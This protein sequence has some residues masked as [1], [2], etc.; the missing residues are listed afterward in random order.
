MNP[1]DR[2]G[3]EEAL[4]ARMTKFADEEVLLTNSDDEDDDESFRGFRFPDPI[5][6]HQISTLHL[7]EH[8]VHGHSLS[9]E[10]LFEIQQS[11]LQAEL[12][13][14][15]MLLQLISEETGCEAGVLLQAG[16]ELSMADP[17]GGE[18]VL[19]LKQT[20]PD[21]RPLL[22]RK[23]D[24]PGNPGFGEG[25]VQLDLSGL[26]EP[27]QALREWRTWV[28]RPFQGA[29][30][31]EQDWLVY[32][33]R[34]VISY[35]AGVDEPLKPFGYF[36][37]APPWKTPAGT[38]QWG[39]ERS[40]VWTT[41]LELPVKPL[42]DE[43]AA[44]T[45]DKPIPRYQMIV[46]P[47]QFVHQTRGGTKW[48]PCEFDI[49]GDGTPSLVGGMRSHK[50]PHL[51][52]HVA[53]PVLSEALPLL[54]KLRR[55][56]LLL[57]DRRLQVVFKAQRIIVPGNSGDNSDAEYVGLW[58][59]DGLRENVAAVVLYYYHV[60]PSLRGGDME[61]CGREPMDVLGAGDCSNNIDDLG[62]ESLRLAFRGK[63]KSESDK[64]AAVHNCRVPI[65]EGT[66]LVFSNYQ[67][68]HRVLRMK[69]TGETEASRDF[70]AL[71]V[72][73]PSAP[74]LLPARS[75]LAA[76]HLLTR[77]LAPANIPISEIQIVLEFLGVS[78]TD[79][80]R[81]LQRNRLLSEQLKP[82][83]EFACA[84]SAKVH[85]TG[86]GCYT[87]IGWLHKLL[88]DRDP[89][90]FDEVNPKGL[91]RL[92]ALNLAPEGSDRGL[93]EAL[94]LPTA[95]LKQR[96][97]E[98]GKGSDSEL[99]S[100]HAF[101]DS[102]EAENDMRLAESEDLKVSE[103]ALTG[104]PDDVSKTWKLKPK[105]EGEPEKL[106]PEVCVFS[107]CNVTNG[108]GRG[109]VTAT[110]MRTRI[111]RIAQLIAGEEGP[112]K[113]CFC[114]PDTSANQTPLQRN[115]EQLGAKIG[116]LAIVVCVA[117][118]IIGVV[119][120]RKDLDSPESPA[121]LYMV[122]I[123]VTLAVAAIPEGIPLCVTISL[124]IGCSDMVK[125]HVLVRK[126]A[127]V[128]T[129]GSASVICS[130][131]TGTLTEGKMTM[132]SMWSGDVT[133]DVGGK[134]FDPTVGKITAPGGEDAAL[135]LGVKTTLLSGL[136]CCNTTLDKVKDAD[137]GEE[138]WEP[139]GNS[140]EA[141]IVVAAR[142]IGFSEDVATD[143]PREL[144][145][146]FSSSRK[147][148]LTVCS[149]S[150]RHAICDG[151]MPL[152][153]GTK[154]FLVCKGA[155]NFIIDLCEE[156]LRD[157]G[158]VA[159]MTDEAR[160]DILKVVDEYSSKALRVLAVAVRT[161]TELPFDK[162]DD[163]ISTD[164][165][166]AKLRQNL[167]L[168]GLVASIDPDRDGVKDSVLAARG[169]GIRVVMIT[170]DYLKTAI[171]IAKNVSILQPQDD[172]ATA[173]VDCNTLRPGGH[174]LE[175][176]E[177]DRLT[178]T[179]RVFARAK[180]EDK[181]E[182]VKSIQRMGQ[183]A[184]MTGDGVND[185]PALNQ[186]NIGVAMGI[187]GTEVAKGASDMVLTDDNFCSIVSAVEKGR[188]I[189]SGIQKFVAFIMSVHIAE[190][191]QIFACIVAGIPVMRTP[192]QIL[193]LI[194]VTD[195]PP[196]IALGMEPGE[197]GILN[198]RPRPKTEP[199]VLGWM[200]FAMVLNGAVLSIVIIAVYIISLI[201]Y[202]D[203]QILQADIMALGDDAA[204]KLSQART[205]TFISLVWSENIRSYI[206]RSFDK[207][208][209][210]NLCG[211]SMM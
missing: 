45:L 112:K 166:F 196:S 110:G 121:A 11:R 162:N 69:N 10:K 38:K 125:Q 5:L 156:R 197:P 99:G 211:N 129:L 66:L 16:R 113:K 138:K 202:C 161:M 13:T 80:M 100:P 145:I 109:I 103:M 198:Q 186:A 105:K 195:L 199:I 119:L 30:N 208:F 77:T 149:V 108:K 160:Q 175:G 167:R 169:A 96:L 159:K 84:G 72:L 210:V 76:P 200:W 111:G 148:M 209:W 126:L 49:S 191:M 123:A 54:A 33:Q 18:G 102:E 4:S 124:S 93:S 150:G 29:P 56:Q 141:P 101:A 91:E 144:E 184:A 79:V 178:S 1:N 60:D 17:V 65:G 189:Y 14:A 98:I 81:K 63:S 179:V 78:Q 118:F 57:D 75:V 157:D 52:Q 71:F 25:E 46:D 173:A 85:C 181:L 53:C 8:G 41:R 154:H 22:C 104:E 7:D 89:D 131:K 51:A 42:L 117:V 20:I 128:E 153:Q 155:P 122:L 32:T 3:Y 177:M 58:H 86:N 39:G 27:V 26:L 64:S 188:A 24:R 62:S 70:V 207:P 170:G 21:C 28:T 168:V 59:V 19:T 94:S 97:K 171:A 95:K 187:Q 205:V 136:L 87:M 2:Y 176:K 114:L 137:T 163:E 180:P 120:Q 158:S 9:G 185:A 130:D 143:Y 83:G 151:G 12:L 146:P 43:H 133:Y 40:D 15:G 116:I 61:F 147:M 142:K 201:I 182:I 127:A 140:S 135:H 44:L 203:G 50:Y 193:F 164:E 23:V 152:P 6:R 206:A 82:S 190:V 174:Y 204:F 36:P 107:G 31:G 73:D 115:L 106:T 92:A 192:L 74:A 67:M 35:G 172:E 55:P 165:R 34:E 47:N 134:G 88:E 132:V 68:A 37:H 194:L 90:P 48:V 183:V 139:R